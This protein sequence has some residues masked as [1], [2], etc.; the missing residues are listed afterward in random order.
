MLEAT[1]ANCFW[2]Q[3]SN[4][5]SPWGVLPDLV[6]FRVALCHLPQQ[7]VITFLLGM[8]SYRLNVPVMRVIGCRSSQF[9][10]FW[11]LRFLI[12]TTIIIILHLLV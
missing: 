12:V 11:M 10:T 7:I 3:N 4:P 2:P 8:S 9:W 5:K 6:A 1:E